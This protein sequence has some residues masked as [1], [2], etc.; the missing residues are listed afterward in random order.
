MTEEAAKEAR[1]LIALGYCRTSN[2]YRM[3]A[4]IDRADWVEVMAKE[5]RRAPADFCIPGETEPT[6]NWCDQ[7]RRCFSNDKIEVSEEVFKLMPP[8]GHN[9]TGWSAK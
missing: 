2:K 1:E 4:R 5:Y 3:L 7:Y 9:P 8:S 6:G